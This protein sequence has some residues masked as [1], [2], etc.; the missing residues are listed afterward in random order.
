MKTPQNHLPL[1]LSVFH[2]AFTALFL[3]YTYRSAT[4]TR[5]NCA[6]S[7]LTPNISLFWCPSFVNPVLNSFSH[8]HLLMCSDS[9]PIFLHSFPHVTYNTDFVCQIFNSKLPSAHT[10]PLFSIFP[11]Y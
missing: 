7:L 10:L 2:P 6:D 1:L 9:M 4:I 5:P 3:K 8:T 11:T